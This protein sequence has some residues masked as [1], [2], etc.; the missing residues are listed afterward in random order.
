MHNDRISIVD[1]ADGAFSVLGEVSLPDEPVIKKIGFSSNSE[2]AY[3][4]THKRQ[5]PFPTLYEIR[6]TPPYQIS[7]RLPI[8]N[9]DL[10]GVAVSSKCKRIFVSDHG[11]KKIWII[12]SRSFNIIDSLQIGDYVPGTLAINNQ[13]DMLAVMIPE[14]RRAFLLNPATSAVMGQM[15]G[16]RLK[17]HDAVFTDDGKKLFIAILSEKGGLA[18]INTSPLYPPPSV[19][20]ASNRDGDNFQI[21]RMDLNGR[22]IVQ[23]T[24]NHATNCCPHWS[25]DGL[26]IAFISDRAG[27]PKIVLMNRDGKEVRILEKTDP[28]VTEDF[29]EGDFLSWSPDGKR[30]AFIGDERRAVRIVDIQTEDVQTILK[31]EIAPGYS[32]Y[33]GVS[34]S[35][36][37]GALYISCHKSGNGYAHRFFHMNLEQMKAT[38]VFNDENRTDVRAKP[39]VAPDGKLIAVLLLPKG[40][41]EPRPILLRNRM[42]GTEKELNGTG[43]QFN[44]ALHWSTDG[45]YLTYSSGTAHRQHLFVVGV[46]GQPAVP[47][48]DEGD[49]RDMHPDL[50]GQVP[51]SLSHN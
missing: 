36:S 49:W 28:M 31:G 5:S 38:E 39:A 35:S 14:S 33:G 20:F 23:L 40:K 7:R 29:H 41:D 32:S 9:G 51:E 13:E 8:P 50:F 26:R 22:K 16:L 4:N 42:D 45:K 15:D 1:V 17:A 27:P 37:D 3:V 12:D 10:R 18:V 6:L 19:V 24:T 30:I 48:T 2:F 44:G 34:W 21:C 46:A 47:L 25:P 43:G 11:N